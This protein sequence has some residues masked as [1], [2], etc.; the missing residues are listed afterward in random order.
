[1]S[2][3]SN[4]SAADGSAGASAAPRLS[5]VIPAKDRI[6]ELERALDSV[7]AQTER[8]FEIIVVDDGSEAALEPR[9]GDA[10][11]DPRLRFLRQPNAG[12]AVARNNGVAA[13]RGE[14][15]AFLDSDDTWEPQKLERQAAC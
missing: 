10:H 15:V 9:I 12:P 3:Q 8:D 13:A 7:I 5:V 14:L 1:M 6:E 11:R 4:G 2:L